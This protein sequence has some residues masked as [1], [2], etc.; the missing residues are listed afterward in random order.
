MQ[1][2]TQRFDHCRFHWH[3][4]DSRYIP[5]KQEK[6]IHRKKKKK[7]NNWKQLVFSTMATTCSI[8]PEDKHLA[9]GTDFTKHL[10]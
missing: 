6:L 2:I 9:A 1:V 10:I 8:F 5:A 3:H 7:D 4:I